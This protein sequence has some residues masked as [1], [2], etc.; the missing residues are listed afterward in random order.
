MALFYPF[1]IILKTLLATLFVLFTGLALQAQ[2]FSFLPEAGFLMTQIDG[3]KLH[4]FHKKGF[5]IGI[6]TNYRLYDDIKAAIK[7]SYYSQGSIRKSRFQ[8]KLPEGVQLE[9]GLNTIGLELSTMYDPSHKSLFLGFGLVHH[10]ILDFDF[11]IVDNVVYG[12]AKSLNPE[13]VANSFNNVKFFLGWTF[14]TSYKFAIGYERSLTDILTE[15]FINIARLRPYLLSFSFSYELNPG[16][17][18]SQKK[19]RKKRR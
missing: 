11:N 3:D 16:K 17:K 19:I 13:I 12:P 1:I 8:D 5:K 6:G 15:D 18:R 4:G 2:K 10:Q 14:A 9:M 7:T